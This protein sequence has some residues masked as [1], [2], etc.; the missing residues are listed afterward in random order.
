MN[1]HVSQ[2]A[3]NGGVSGGGWGSFTFE[4]G[5][6]SGP[7]G[8]GAAAAVSLHGQA[9]SAQTGPALPQRP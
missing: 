2:G 5:G 4:Q 7:G 8:F 1:E 3:T 6:M 9:R